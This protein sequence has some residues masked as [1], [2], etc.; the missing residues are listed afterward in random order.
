MKY[1]YHYSLISQDLWLRLLNSL[2]LPL[3]LM[4]SLVSTYDVYAH[5]VEAYWST[6]NVYYNIAYHMRLLFF[7]MLR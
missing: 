2:N 6:H 7:L 5:C 1:Y 3:S 4:H